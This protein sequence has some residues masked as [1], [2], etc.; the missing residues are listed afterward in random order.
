M[1]PFRKIRAAI[2]DRFFRFLRKALV[3]NDG[4][5]AVAESLRG[6]IDPPPHT[7]A[8]LQPA[9]APYS[10]V[11]KLNGQIRAGDRDDIIFLTGR[12]RSASTLLWNVF[13]QIEG[14]TSFY[15]P[16]NERQWFNPATRGDRVDGT[17]RRVSDYWRE[18]EGLEELGR[19]YREDWIRRGLYMDEQSW[20]PAMRAYVERIIERSPG[21]PVLQFNRIDFRLPW[22]RRHFPNAR[23]VH[24]Y[25]HP[26]DQWC[27]SLR[28]LDSFSPDAG[29]LNDFAKADRFYLRTWVNDLKYH[30]P[31]LADETLHPYRHFYW[32]WKLSYLYG[33]KYADCSVC[34]EELVAH[35]RRE[36]ET[37]FERLQIAVDDWSTLEGIIEKPQLGKWKQYADDEWFREH[38]IE[39]ERVLAEFL[40]VA[41]S[42]KGIGA[43][44]VAQ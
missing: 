2:R 8:D 7:A 27:S 20:D 18:F 14:C 5:Q 28:D 11:G 34:F 43:N 31:F 41:K 36:L 44:A 40:R 25:R 12:F 13:R 24:A 22:F 16:F 39:C 37:L 4:K 17:H 26:R 9:D 3:H 38:E 33:V 10:D 30:F 32:L 19:Y 15:E 35:P 1:N 6:L 29:G 42:T 23:I 21:R